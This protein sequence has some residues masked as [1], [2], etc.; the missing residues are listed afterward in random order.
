[1]KAFVIDASHSTLSIYYAKL[2]NYYLSD[3]VQHGA[4]YCECVPL[5]KQY[6]VELQ[7]TKKFH[8]RIT[9][10]RVELFRLLAK[11]LYY[12]S[13]GKSHVGYLFNYEQNP[14]HQIIYPPVMN[15]Q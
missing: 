10:E 6:T 15:S 2:P 5:E 14:I 13:S 3:I 7:C 12:L 8:M 9:S 11:L 1:M 4:K